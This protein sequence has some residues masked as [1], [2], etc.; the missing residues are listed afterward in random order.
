MKKGILALFIS[1]SSLIAIIL[2]AAVLISPLSRRYIVKHS[3][4]LTGRQINIDRLRI[5]IFNGSLRVSGFA[6]AEADDSTQ[7]A[8]LGELRVRMSLP[9]LLNRKVIIKSI[10][11]DSLCVNIVQNGEKFN[12]SDIVERFSSDTASV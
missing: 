9:Q 5:N 2:L 7:F 3:K 1:V 6:I 4:E 12:F 11:L 8:S 10:S